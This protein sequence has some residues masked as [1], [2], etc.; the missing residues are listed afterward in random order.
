MHG[1]NVWPDPTELPGWEQQVQ[2]YFT[3]MLDLSRVIARG[4]ALSLSLPESFFTDKMRDPVA[5]LLLLR[6]PPAPKPHGVGAA[7]GGKEQH[8][9]G[10]G[11]HTDCG[12]L[13]ILAQVREEGHD[14]GC[15]AR[16]GGTCRL[17][18]CSR[19]WYNQR[20]VSCCV[21]VNHARA[22]SLPVA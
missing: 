6:Y 7:A 16:L 5:Q 18:F 22:P 19:L 15:S 3:A 20:Q 11:A 1:P 14:V 17:L 21:C 2:T 10:C 9:V 13:T 4:L 12:F 8:Y